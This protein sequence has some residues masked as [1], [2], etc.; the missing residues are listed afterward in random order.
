M[1]SSDNVYVTEQNN[2]RVQKFTD[3]RRLRF[4][5]GS[6]GS[7]EGQFHWPHDIAVDGD[8][9]IFVADSGNHRIQKFAPKQ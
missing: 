7:D 2:H 1:D 4:Q 8:G 6:D 3:E 9:Y 5:P